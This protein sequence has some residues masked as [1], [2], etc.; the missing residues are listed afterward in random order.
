M[1]SATFEPL[2]FVSILVKHEGRGG[3][4]DVSG[5]FGVEAEFGDTLV[6]SLVGYETLEFTLLTLEPG[7]IRLVERKTLLQQIIVRDTR[8][9]PYEGLFDEQNAL[10]E[11]RSMPFY[12]SKYRKEKVRLNWSIED[13][14]RART[15]LDL[16]VKNPETKRGLM[17]KHNLTEQQY[18][19]IL[20][21]FNEENEEIMYFLS[22]AELLSLIN[23]FF[24][25]AT[26]N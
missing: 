7:F 4:T 2:P 19:D 9:T 5:R 15:Y 10:L 21:Q 24:A 20:T 6:F 14:L 23:N 13:A 26:R 16:V 11:N 8:L 12:Y 1:D 3:T 22:G 17:S 25:R 18:Y